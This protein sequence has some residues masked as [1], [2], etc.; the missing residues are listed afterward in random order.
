MMYMITVES[1]TNEHV[2][3]LDTTGLN[4]HALEDIIISKDLFEIVQVRIV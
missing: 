1:V 4:L 2:T 3:R